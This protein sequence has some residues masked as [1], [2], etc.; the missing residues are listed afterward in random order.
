MEV[1][2]KAGK[3]K[4]M[5]FFIVF[6]SAL[7]LSGISARI[8]AV[9]AAPT[10]GEK[11]KME[12]AG[13][14]KKALEAEKKRM[15]GMIGELNNLKAD[16]SAYVSRL[17]RDMTEIETEISRLEV[18]ISE[19]E[20][21]VSEAASEL[22]RAESE[23][24]R[25]YADMKLRI[26]YMY[27]KGDTGFIELLF[28]S[29]NLAEFFNRAEYVQKISEYDR[30]QLSV[31]A[32][33]CEQIREKG[34]RLLEE[35]EQLEILC[36][37]TQAKRDS[38]RRLM[39]EKL[40]EI[41]RYASEIGEA[42]DELS[43]Y[44]AQIAEQE[45]EIKAI[46]AAVKK[47]EEE[48]KKAESG[49][50]IKALGEIQFL[51]PCP[52]R[53]LITSPF[54]K[55]NSPVKGASSYHQ[56]IDIA[57]PTGTEIKAAAEGEVVSASYS[58]TAGNFIMLRHGGGVYTLYMHCASLNVKEGEQVEAGQTI[59]KV[60]ST[61]ISTGPHLHFALRSGGKYLNPSEYVRP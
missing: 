2:K 11:K 21:S 6:S 17:D 31:Y 36:V 52:G 22:A 34:K 57:A 1:K 4:W 54:G 48:E 60:G 43:A 47:R 37:K 59:A 15:Q 3:K 18:D 51:W 50:P 12:H 56:G 49:A 25:Q 27:E 53:N 61:G 39:A 30:A 44:Q 46:E 16:T 42:Q 55:R 9:H 41:E 40:K 10:A 20:T 32:D 8:S 7:L 28:S 29:K 26:Q 19:K 35:K 13:E 38:T 58:K 14:K 45:A 33:V 23:R 5:R 24:D